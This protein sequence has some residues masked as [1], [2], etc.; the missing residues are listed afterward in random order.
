VRRLIDWW[1]DLIAFG[2]RKNDSL[3]ID[4]FVYLSDSLVRFALE[5][6]MLSNHTTES[7]ATGDSAAATEDSFSNA[8][9]MT[10]TTT[11]VGESSSALTNLE[12]TTSVS[13]SVSGVVS[14]STTITSAAPVT[15]TSAAEITAGANRLASE[16]REFMQVH[17]QS[18]LVTSSAANIHNNNSS[19]SLESIGSA[20]WPAV[21]EDATADL[22]LATCRKLREVS[23]I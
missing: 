10:T 12:P 7:S 22:Q 20:S 16:L 4:T 6:I 11:A 21:K 18:F 19:N 23:A 17:E 1:I 15:G 3:C 9:A 2:E 5:I 8:G 14:A 13:I